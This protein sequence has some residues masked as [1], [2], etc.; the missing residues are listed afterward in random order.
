MS[1][2]PTTTTRVYVVPRDGKKRLVRA[3]HPVHAHAHVYDV[4]DVHVA[5]QSEL[6]YLL[7]QGVKIEEIPAGDA[8]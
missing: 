3:T 2:K 1:T 5:N 6:I 4:R 7:G 8:P